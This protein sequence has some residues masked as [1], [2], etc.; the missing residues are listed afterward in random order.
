MCSLLEPA[1]AADHIIVGDEEGTADSAM[2]AFDSGESLTRPVADTNRGLG[3]A[4]SVVNATDVG[5][6]TGLCCP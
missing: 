3:T 2:G 5:G 6:A 4:A 1:N